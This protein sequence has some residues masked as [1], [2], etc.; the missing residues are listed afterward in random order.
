[1]PPTKR[2]SARAP[3]FQIRQITM[4]DSPL[5]S[6]GQSTL[7]RPARPSHPPVSTSEGEC[8]NERPA[9]VFAVPH[10]TQA[11]A[12]KSLLERE[13][14]HGTAHARE[15]RI[16]NLFV[17]AQVVSGAEASRLDARQISGDELHGAVLAGR[18]E[19][20]LCGIH[21]HD[22]CEELA[23]HRLCKLDQRRSLSRIG[24]RVYNQDDFG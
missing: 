23:T 14:G 12:A 20:N 5:E 21:A 22:V 3:F 16:V 11:L 10:C 7:Q 9:R 24:S 2:G 1:M 18:G 15:G 4:S 13:R 19:V 6:K 8:C 17:A